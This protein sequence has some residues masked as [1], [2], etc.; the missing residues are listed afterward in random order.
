M[1]LFITSSLNGPKST[2]NIS[3]LCERF[4]VAYFRIKEVGIIYMTNETWKLNKKRIYILIVE[5]VSIVD[6]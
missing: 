1:L 3:Q 2:G 6:S 4:Q 5:T